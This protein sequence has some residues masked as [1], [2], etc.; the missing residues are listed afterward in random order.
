MQR[1]VRHYKETTGSKE[2]D[3]HEV[4]AWAVKRGWPLPKPL[5]PFDR[6]VKEFAQAERE[7]IRHDATTGKPY[8]A[9][10]A[11]PLMR[12]G[13]QIFF[14]V[15]ID[16]APRPHM[17]KSLTLRR[18]QMIGD[19]LQLTFDAAHWNSVNPTEEPIKVEMDF[20]PDIEWRMNAPDEDEKKS[21]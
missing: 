1:I 13:Q 16:E 2:V 20:N 4:V 14:W 18:D 11:V 21:G 19:G 9:N 7:E 10:H 17:Q 8:R 6:L 12:N 5:D 15:D 3:L